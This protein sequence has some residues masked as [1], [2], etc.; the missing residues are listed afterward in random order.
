MQLERFDVTYLTNQRVIL[1]PYR[2]AGQYQQ[3]PQAAE[4][5]IFKR[6]WWAYKAK[7]E[8][9][10]S[11]EYIVQVWGTA[12]REGEENAYSVCVTF[13]WRRPYI[14]IANVLRRQMEWPELRRTSIQHYLKWQLPILLFE[15]ASGSM[16]LIDDLK[17][18]TD[19]VLP[20]MPVKADTD[21]IARANAATGVV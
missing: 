2:Y 16:S 21:K 8:W 17:T 11:F 3:K 13:G 15:D 10:E 20:I 4:G 6:T 1:G 12:Q 14:C 5:G 18:I 7:S 19:P 9:P